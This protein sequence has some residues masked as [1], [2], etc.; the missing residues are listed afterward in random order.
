MKTILIS[1]MLL[2]GFSAQSYGLD[3]E[4]Y[5]GKLFDSSL[6]AEPDGGQAS[7][8]AGMEIGHRIGIIRAYTG[9]DTLCDEYND[10]GTFHPSSVRYEIGIEANVYDGFWIEASHMC[11]HPVDK[12]GTVEQYNMIKAVLKFGDK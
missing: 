8:S 6:R 2:I 12:S 7:Y 1:I 9:I 11:W 5:F 4:V 3:G 10:D